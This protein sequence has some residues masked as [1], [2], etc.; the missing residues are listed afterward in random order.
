MLNERV[1]LCCGGPNR[2]KIICGI[3]I[4]IIGTVRPRLWAGVR[5]KLKINS[6]YTF[7]RHLINLPEKFRRTGSCKKVILV[8]DFLFDFIPLR[9]PQFPYFPSVGIQRTKSRIKEDEEKIAQAGACIEFFVPC[10]FGGIICIIIV[11]AMVYLSES[12]SFFVESSIYI[13]ENFAFK[14]AFRFQRNMYRVG[15]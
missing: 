2:A 9:H 5:H 12:T 11:E 4:I 8:C 13:A 14:V 15:S 6:S 10:V 1:C 7:C 3:G